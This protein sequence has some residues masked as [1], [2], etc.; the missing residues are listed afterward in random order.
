MWVVSFVP[1]LQI[2][3]CECC[4]WFP[5]TTQ[6]CR[7][8]IFN[9]VPCRFDCW[10]LLF[11]C[12]DSFVLTTKIKLGECCVRLQCI[13][14]WCYICAS[15][16]VVCWFDANG[17]WVLCWRTSFVVSFVFTSQTEFCE[18]CVW[19]QCI[20]QWCCTSFSNVVVCWFD[21]NGKE[22][23]VDG[24]HFTCFFC[25]HFPERAQWVL[26]LISM[27]HSMMS[28]LFLQCRCLLIWLEWKREA[29]WR[30]PFLLVSFVFTV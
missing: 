16:V 21:E 10:L 8:R 29:N 15:E 5:C 1:T 24:C 20:T 13:T 19:F 2:N 23:I 12:V 14:Q 3:F 6:W 9:V 17:R 4:V 27:N 11:M 30:M 26:C 7:C 18:C 25:V 28:H 22:W